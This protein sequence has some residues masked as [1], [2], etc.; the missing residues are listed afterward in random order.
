MAPSL[1]FFSRSSLFRKEGGV[2]SAG[3]HS[4]MAPGGAPSKLSHF[5]L[6]LVASRWL[7]NAASLTAFRNLGQQMA[8]FSEF[9]L[10]DANSAR[11]ELPADAEF[12]ACTA[13]NG[14]R[15]YSEPKLVSSYNS[16]EN[17]G[18]MFDGQTST[19]WGPYR[20]VGHFPIFDFDTGETLMAPGGSY[21]AT[22][23]ET[24]FG[25]GNNIF[26]PVAV[27][28]DVSSKPVDLATFSRWQLINANDNASQTN[29]TIVEVEVLG[30]GDGK[31][32]WRL[33]V[34]N[35]A[36]ATNTNYAV[37]HSGSLVPRKGDL[38]SDLDLADRD[39]ANGIAVDGI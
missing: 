15:H 10:I 26:G 9:Q 11:Y 19:K 8:Q 7:R 28:V 37:V 14:E 29:R 31:T 17:I 20:Y 33:A 18:R 6:K 39:W 24:H 22:F 25:Y 36:N 12:F 3:H 35:N 32:W 4:A 2:I 38:W 1:P 21:D 5:C 27:V 13:Y 16:G 34:S 23:Y 30:S